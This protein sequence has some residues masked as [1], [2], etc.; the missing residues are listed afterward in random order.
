MAVFPAK[1]TPPTEGRT[2]ERSDGGDDS[3]GGITTANAVLTMGRAVALANALTPEQNSRV[4]INSPSSDTT[5]EAFTCP[6]YTQISQNNSVIRGS[7]DDVMVELITGSGLSQRS[8]EN[9][10]SD[11]ASVT[12]RF[13]ASFAASCNAD[14]VQNTDGIAIQNV[15]FNFVSIADVSLVAFGNIGFDNQDTGNDVFNF[16]FLRFEAQKDNSTCVFQ[17]GTNTIVMRGGRLGEFGMTGVT[18]IKAS[19]GIVDIDIN[20]I[21]CEKGLWATST[22]LIRGGCNLIDGS[23]VTE[24]T[25]HIDLTCSECT[26]DITIGTGTT[27][28]LIILEY[29]HVANTVTNN[30]T[31]N[32]IIGGVRYG[33]WKISD[34]DIINIESWQDVKDNLAPADSTKGYKVFGN[35]VADDT[36]SIDLNGATLY[37]ATGRSMDGFTSTQ[38]SHTLFNSTKTSFISGLKFA[39]SGTTSKVF[40]IA[41][42]TGFETMSLEDCSFNGNTEIGKISGIFALQQINNVYQNNA[43]G[44]EVENVTNYAEQNTSW[45]QNNTAATNVTYTGA[46]GLIKITGGGMGV[47]S[48]KTGVNVSGITSI[49]SFAQ[50]NGGYAFSGA[51]TYVD[52]VTVFENK[53]WSVES[54]GIDKVY[55]DI[56]SFGNLSKDGSTTTTISVSGTPVKITGATTLGEAFRMGD[57]ATDNRIVNDTLS[58]IALHYYRLCGC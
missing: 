58:C 50:I 4:A 48:G 57:G 34:N 54:Y 26:G 46:F 38:A 18:G 56:Q 27:A 14:A 52:D 11:S 6:E 33:T 28:N 16:S 39:V 20:L 37:G 9:E 53:E 36:T 1:V 21:D 19:S 15:G 10:S 55:K 44:L 17:R 30:G 40:D 49:A 3:L 45:I 35:I 23:I 24:D 47:A 5:T 51:G 32:G 31:L 8:I 12:V 29:D 42:A 22:G 2:L 7:D 13:N 41:G 43:G 25:S